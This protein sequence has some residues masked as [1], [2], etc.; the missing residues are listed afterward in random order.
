MN[1]KS[2]RQF[3][4]FDT[5][6]WIALSSLLLC[7]LS[8]VLLAI[9]YDF[10]RAYRS[11][12]Q[13]LM[14]NPA[15]LFIRNMHYW[16]A[17]FFFIFTLLHIFDHFFKSTDTNVKSRRTW[18]ILC[19]ALLFLGY[20]MIS[21]FMLKGDAA[22]LQARRIV[23]SM[24]ESVPVLGKMLSSALTGTEDNWLIVYIQHVATG[25]ILLVMA[26]YE[27]L[28]TF[29]PKLKTLVTVFLLLLPLSWMVR[30]PL[31]QEESNLLKGPWFFVGIQE[32]LHRSSHPVYIVAL[33]FL[34][35]FLLYLLPVLSPGRRAL[36][37]KVLLAV[38]VLYL[39]LTLLV[40][41][42]R[43]GNWEWKV[44][45]ESGNSKEPGLVIDPV[46]FNTGPTP[47]TMAENSKAE[48]CLVCHG[49]MKG[50]SVSH[51][52]STTGCYVCHGGDPFSPGKEKAHKNMY[53]VPGDFSNVAQT[54]GTQ[55]CHPEISGRVVNSL[56]ATQS[57]II[58]V[59]KFV[60]GEAS[61]LN[62]SFHVRDLGHTAADTHLRNLCAGCH[63]GNEKKATGQAGWLER[64]GGCNAC[65]LHYDKRAE[66]SMKRMQLKSPAGSE[67][68]HPAIDIRVSD[69]RCRSCHSRS[70]RISLN[71]EGWNESALTQ[72]GAPDTSRY[73]V[74]PDERLL[75][76]VQ[77]D[78]HHQKGMACIDCHTSAETMGDGGNHRHKEEA[79]HVQCIDCHPTGKHVGEAIRDLPD[80]ESRMVAWLRNYDAGNRVV[81]TARSRQP[82]LNTRVDSLGQIWLTGKITDRPHLCKPASAACSRGEGHRRLNC[83]SCHTAWV[84]QCIG[85]H[86]A[87]EKQIPGFDLL[88]GEKRNGTWIEYAGNALAEP[89][90]LGVSEK[91][92]SRIVT[93]VPGMILTIDR[94]SFEKGKGQA[95]HRL[96][97]PAS[98]HT[99][100]RKSRGCRSCHNDPL[101]IGFGR[102]ELKYQISGGKGEWKFTPKFASS[103]GDGL[104]EDAWTGF[105]QEAAPPFATRDHLRPFSLAEQRAILTVGSCFTCHPEDSEVSGSMLTDFKKSLAGRSTRCVLPSW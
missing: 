86:N 67:E 102:G 13:L 15:G 11:V 32:M 6:G 41:L 62:D 28:K 81:L 104:P 78:I 63:L 103:P 31:G 29:W 33:L 7:G 94:E 73:R 59:D 69:D 84:P 58:A 40:F 52:P 25:T 23:G 49:G 80:R 22:G 97:A 36:V 56:M 35:L 24:L 50:L 85:C 44:A 70:G 46:R 54:C 34:I 61:T 38:S 42:F 90:V 68:V 88:T 105:L 9:P 99:T 21:G 95:F 3:A 43:G 37:K 20:E 91:T 47:K 55:S 83:E 92:E 100:Q 16:S 39:L 26:V 77:A 57:G 74:L 27:H 101:A 5:A 12:F 8:G 82:L 87:Y 30:A 72:P 19:I 17:Q 1:I 14:F 93:A 96:Y 45:R 51:N 18:L 76:R 48:S 4:Q 60:F 53:R 10:T 2:L 89:P 79:L 98:A 65:H 64:G 75:E 71:Y 66:E